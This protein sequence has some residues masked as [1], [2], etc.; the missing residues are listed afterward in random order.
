M[1]NLADFFFNLV[2]CSP[3]IFFFFFFFFLQSKHKKDM[4]V[5]RLILLDKPESEVHFFSSLPFLFC[6]HA[7]SA[8]CFCLSHA[9]KSFFGLHICIY[10]YIYIYIFLGGARTFL[11]I[12]PHY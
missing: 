9:V 7:S 5:T 4:S 12:S 2:F 3:L 1:A 11:H 10:I 6:T 8:T